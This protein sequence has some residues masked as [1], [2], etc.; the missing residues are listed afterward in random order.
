LLSGFDKLADRH[1]EGADK[2]NFRALEMML[3]T[4]GFI[5]LNRAYFVLSERHPYT[6]GA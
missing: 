1:V 4:P 3:F 5:K 2:L 6:I